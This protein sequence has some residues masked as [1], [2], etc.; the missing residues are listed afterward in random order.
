MNEIIKDYIHQTSYKIVV[1]KLQISCKVLTYVI[2]Q[3]MDEMPCWHFV[4]HVGVCVGI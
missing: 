2:C 3:Q 1:N 4:R